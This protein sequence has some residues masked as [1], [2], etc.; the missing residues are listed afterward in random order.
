MEHNVHE[1]VDS[2]ISDLTIQVNRLVENTAAMVEQY[3]TVHNQVQ[4]LVDYM[5]AHRLLDD[6]C[7]TF[8]DGETVYSTQAAD[9]D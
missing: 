3:N 2:V 9:Q 5:D 6:H 8:P 4:F 1:R 7:F